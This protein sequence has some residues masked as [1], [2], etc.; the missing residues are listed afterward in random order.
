[1]ALGELFDYGCDSV[2]TVF[3]ALSSAILIG[4]SSS[5]AFG[6]MTAKL[7][8]KLVIAHV[9]KAE[10]EYFDWPL[11]GSTINSSSEKNGTT[12]HPRASRQTN[13]KH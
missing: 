7:T 1:M 13:R 11:L 10:M 8:N 12:A 6:L 3:V 9:T 5:I 2:S 4:H